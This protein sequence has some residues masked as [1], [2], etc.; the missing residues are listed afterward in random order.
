MIK[1]TLISV[2]QCALLA[3]GQ[4]CLKLAM[5]RMPSFSWSW[6][7]FKSLLLNYPFALAGIFFGGSTVLWMYILRH[8]PFSLAYPFTSVAYVFGMFAAILVFHESIPVTRWI[9]V[10]LIMV[11]VFFLVK[12]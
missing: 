9:G 4:V 8:Y 2:L 3:C 1:F 5:A 6:S 12:Q 7:Y 10:A 11:G